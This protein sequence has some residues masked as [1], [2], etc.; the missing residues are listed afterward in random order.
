MVLA[1]CRSA[2]RSFCKVSLVSIHCAVLLFGLAGLFGKTIELSSL[3][4][5]WGRTVLAALA[6]GFALF[7][8]R[9]RFAIK[10]SE[11]LSFVLMGLLLAAHWWTFFHAIQLATVAIGLL[12]FAT[13]PIVV[14]LLEPFTDGVP[15][16]FANLGYALLSLI[17]VGLVLPDL[18]F[19]TDQSLGGMWGIISGVLY[20]LVTIMN[21]RYAKKYSALTI[22][23][24]QYLI[25]GLIL[26]LIVL[27][28][29]I[30][31]N[32][33]SL[34]QLFVLGI[35]FTAFAHALFIHGMR[36]VQAG[37]ASLIGT[38]E[39]VYGTAAAAIL[40]SEIPNGRTVLGGSLVV[41][42]AGFVSLSQSQSSDVS[43][44]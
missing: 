2:L 37:T 34:V 26:S 41:L 43:K 44:S 7:I 31:L 32:H 9:K 10:K 6:L 35:V 39:P 24:W 13:F 14:M 17:G 20:A 12:S 1:N 40:L 8:Q 36:E 16:R 23:F 15:F 3:E 38:L 11:F 33:E 28:Q 42:V 27:P 18:G 30:S 25:A 29:G 22:G 21:R 19:Q 5:T 4:I